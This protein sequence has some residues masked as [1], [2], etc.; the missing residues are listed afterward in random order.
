MIFKR[1]KPQFTRCTFQGVIGKRPLGGTIMNGDAE[2]SWSILDSDRVALLH[3]FGYSP[4]AYLGKH[5]WHG[6]FISGAWRSGRPQAYW[7]EARLECSPGSLRARSVSTSVSRLAAVWMS[8]W[9]KDG[10][11][12]KSLWTLNQMIEGVSH[13]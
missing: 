11:I 9:H 5:Q 13:V 4:S 1:Q 12:Y 10:M 6:C 3:A 8:L 7:V 2:H